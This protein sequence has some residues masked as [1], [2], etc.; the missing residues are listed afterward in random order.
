MCLPVLLIADNRIKEF[1]K[2]VITFFFVLIGDDF[3]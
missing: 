1:E 2:I 3:D